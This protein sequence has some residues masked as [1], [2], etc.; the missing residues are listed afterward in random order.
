M[1]RVDV[2]RG[3]DIGEGDKLTH[4]CMLS[5]TTDID[6]SR[7]ERVHRL[8]CGLMKMGHSRPCMHVTSATEGT[9]HV[10]RHLLR[11]ARRGCIQDKVDGSVYK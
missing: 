6:R 4:A 2:G 3:C 7:A 11:G 10:I 8:D 5:C 9:I 1:I